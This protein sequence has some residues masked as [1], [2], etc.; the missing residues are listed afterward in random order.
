MIVMTRICVVILRGWRQKLTR[1]N[2]PAHSGGMSE[3]IKS[4]FPKNDDVF[5]TLS[6]QFNN[7]SV[8]AGGRA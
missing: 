1:N 6:A 2:S 5:R 7:S 8:V 3:Q 4:G